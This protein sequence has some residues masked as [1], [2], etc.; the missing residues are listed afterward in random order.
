MTTWSE[1]MWFGVGVF[2]GV[3]C[4]VVFLAMGGG[5]WR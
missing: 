1:F 5:R 2:V 4:M 3:C